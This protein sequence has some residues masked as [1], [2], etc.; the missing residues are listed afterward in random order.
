MRRGKQR[1]LW[2]EVHHHVPVSSYSESDSTFLYK[3]NTAA[4]IHVSVRPVGW[5]LA[6]LASFLWFGAVSTFQIRVNSKI[7]HD[8]ET[9]FYML[10]D[11]FG[12]SNLVRWLITHL[13]TNSKHIQLL[14]YKLSTGL[15][16]YNLYPTSFFFFLSEPQAIS[17]WYTGGSD[18]KC[19]YTTF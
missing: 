17:Y 16:S 11:S 1:P 12:H 10:A 6:E 8:V 9:L 4:T 19:C 13:V 18:N 14:F 2:C 3:P 7:F 15:Y 5:Q